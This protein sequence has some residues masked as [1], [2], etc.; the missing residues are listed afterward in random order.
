MIVLKS[1][2]NILKTS[3]CLERRLKGLRYAE[4]IFIAKTTY[5]SVNLFFKSVLMF[6]LQL[7]I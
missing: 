4:N 3:V 6:D 7:S 2:L 5:P 1:I